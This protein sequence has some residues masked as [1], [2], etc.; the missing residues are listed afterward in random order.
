MWRMVVPGTIAVLL[1]AAGLALVVVAWRDPRPV[2]GAPPVSERARRAGPPA[3]VS[4][5]RAL[6]KLGSARAATPSGGCS[7][8][9][10]RWTG[11]SSPTPRAAWTST[12]RA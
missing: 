5:A 11:A 10:S 2:P 8:D 1:H 12:A 7:R 4:L 9:A 6:S 3:G